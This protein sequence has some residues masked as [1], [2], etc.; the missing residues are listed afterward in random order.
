MRVELAIARSPL[1]DVRDLV[2]SASIV[3]NG[4]E[5]A[6][7]NAAFLSIP[8]VVLEVRD[9]SGHRVPAA[10]PPVPPTDDAGTGHVE[11][12]PGEM[13]SFDYSGGALFG[14][15][16][17]PGTYSVRFYYRSGEVRSRSHGWRGTLASDWVDFTM[18]GGT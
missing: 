10:P 18:G 4:T 16:P 14:K 11:L 9:G 12:G 7:L 15:T 8:A 6:R 13:L 1:R 5:P 2:V 17:A 3:N